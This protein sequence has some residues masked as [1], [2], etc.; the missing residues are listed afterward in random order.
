MIQEVFLLLGCRTIRTDSFLHATIAPY[1]QE[2]MFFSVCLFAKLISVLQHTRSPKLYVCKGRTP[3]SGRVRVSG[4]L[5]S[6]DYN[7]IW[8]LVLGG[9]AIFPVLW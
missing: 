8:T 6:Q 3:G 7:S 4:L 5:Q 9:S 2:I 1:E